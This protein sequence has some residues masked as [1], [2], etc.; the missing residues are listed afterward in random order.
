MRESGCG[1]HYVTVMLADTKAKTVTSLLPQLT[2]LAL[3][4]WIKVKDV[5]LIGKVYLEFLE[6]NFEVQEEACLFRD[7]YARFYF[8]HSLLY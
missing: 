6:H 5:I 8:L 3:V 1:N 7:L 2:V 4:R